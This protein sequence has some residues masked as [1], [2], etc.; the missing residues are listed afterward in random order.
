MAGAKVQMRQRGLKAH[1]AA[2]APA[3]VDP[4]NWTPAQND[5]AQSAIVMDRRIIYTEVI[6]EP[7][8]VQGMS[9]VSAEFIP[10]GSGTRLVLT[11]Q[12]VAVD[13]SDLLDGVETGWSSALD[14]LGQQFVDA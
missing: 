13:G 8:K 4:A 6:S 5:A 12:T 7:G 9:L 1:R 2:Q 14:R 10:A 3:C 11:L